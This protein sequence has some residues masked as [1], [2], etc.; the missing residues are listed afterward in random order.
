MPK[1]EYALFCPRVVCRLF[2]HKNRSSMSKWKRRDC[3]SAVSGTFVILWICCSR[4]LLLSRLL[5]SREK[6]ST[7]L[8]ARSSCKVQPRVNYLLSRKAESQVHSADVSLA[9]RF[10]IETFD[11]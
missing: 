5:S 7:D 10:G 11:K 6:N 2:A 3:R 1:S 9:F 8:G 4:V